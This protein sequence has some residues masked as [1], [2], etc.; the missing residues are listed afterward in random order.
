MFL[1]ELTLAIGDT[2][3][4]RT[5]HIPSRPHVQGEGSSLTLRSRAGSLT[6]GAGLLLLRRLWDVLGLGEWLEKRTRTL[7]GIYRPSLMIELWTALLCYGGGRMDDLKLFGARGIRRLF[8]WRAV[9]D[10]TT[11]GRFL[12]RCGEQL[13]PVLDQLIWHV[14]RARWQRV[15][16]PSKVML[17]LDSTVSVRYGERQAGAEVGYNPKKRGRPSHHPLLAFL[18]ETGDCLGVIW[19]AGNANT[20]AGG[21]AWIRLLVGRLR[22]AG[23][24]NIKLRLDKGFFS[25]SMVET[26]E[27][28]GVK[29][30]LKVPSYRWVRKRLGHYRRSALHR[31]TKDSLWTASGSLYGARLLS[32]ERCRPLGA[33]DGTYP[34][35]LGD[36]EVVGRSHVLTNIPSIHALTAWRLYNQGAVVEGRIEELYQLSV[37]DTAVDDL[38]GN[39]LL[40][41]MGA[42]AHQLL[43]VLR[44]TSL[45]RG[46]KRAGP[47]QIRNWILRMPARLTRHARKGFVVV[48]QD[49]PL[50]GE[51]TYALGRLVALRAPPLAAAAG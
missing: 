20:A 24:L 14:V 43:H 40:W 4:V 12:R 38:G 27:A 51:L 23:V 17:L 37:G 10:P 28:L 3:T 42:L 50:G 31:S 21:E 19:R 8:G 30:V 9:P 15:G 34:L 13:V 5:H 41:Q 39:A 46:W 45:R 7:P 11:F 16:V 18:A 29:Y 33:R 44:T 47:R 25:K 36:L 35:L 32:V 2:Q 49:E 22:A 1:A 6:D 48:Q 26:L